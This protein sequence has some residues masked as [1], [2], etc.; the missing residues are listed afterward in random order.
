V[1][2]RSRAHDQRVGPPDHGLLLVLVRNTGQD[3]THRLEPGPLLVVA[4]HHGPRGIRQVGVVEHRLLGLGVLV[5]LVQ[6]GQ[7]DRAEL[8]PLNRI[9]LAAHEP[10]QLLG[11]GHREPEL[12][13]QD[14]VPGQHPLEL[15]RLAQE[16]HDLVRVCEA[17][18]PLDACP[19]VPGPVE[20]DD[21]AGR[22]QVRDV[23]LQVPLGLLALGRLVQGH[24]VRAA[25][26]QVLGEPLDRAALARRVTALEQDDQPAL[27]RPDRTL[28]LQHLDLQ[29]ALLLLVGAAAQL[30]PV[31]VVLAERPHGLT[32]RPEQL[33]LAV[34]LV[35]DAQAKLVRQPFQDR[36]GVSV[37]AAGH[38]AILRFPGWPAATPPL[39]AG[40]CGRHPPQDPPFLLAETR[41]GPR[42]A[43]EHPASYP[44]AERAHLA[45][46]PARPAII[47]Q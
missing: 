37:T 16:L 42:C 33:R 47:D 20:H 5:P 25:R 10:A 43:G 40:S 21:L 35:V 2:Q 30:L 29:R 46:R 22:R 7:V 12:D 31:R 39:P 8:P 38:R 34:A 4:L 13:Q 45:R 14:P 27:L 36:I 24:H 11:P 18:H 28:Q 9:E 26:V 32:V 17:H 23:A 19:V 44:G 3:I 6:R 41:P 15:R 1:Q